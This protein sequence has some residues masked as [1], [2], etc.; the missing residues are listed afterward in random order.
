MFKDLTFAFRWLRKSPGFALAAVATIAL[1][2][3]V[4]TAIFSVVYSLLLKPLPYAAPDQLVMV[5]QDMTERGGPPDEWA[6]PGN[7]VDWRSQDATFASMASIRG[8]APSLTGMGD[9]Q[10]LS[11]ESVTQAYFDVL[12]VQPAIGRA[13]RPDEMVPNAPRVV[14]LSDLM[15]RQRFAGSR[16]ALGKSIMLGGE[17]HEIIGV[18][19]PDFR[20]VIAA[21]AD[22]WRPD[23]LNLANPNRGAIVLRVVGR[24][25]PGVTIAGAS[26]AMTTLA[27]DLSQ[28]FPESNRNVGFRVVSLHQQVVGDARPGVLVL[29]GAVLLVL[30]IA[31]VNIANLLLARGAGRTREMAVRTALGAGRMR[32]VRQL[33]TESVVLAVVGGAAGVL[34]SVWG[35]K[36]LIAIAPA[37]TP[38]LNEVSLDPVVLAMAAGLTVLTGLLFGLAPALQMARVSHSSALKDGGRGTVGGGGH[39]LRRVLIVAEIAVALMLLVGGGLLLRSFVAMERADLGFD[40]SNVLVGALTVPPSRLQDP[41][42][43]IAFYD[44]V[45][46]RAG[47]IAGVRRA[48]LTTIVPLGPGGDN[49]MDFTIEGAPPPAPSQP[50]PVTWYRVVSADYVSVMG[51]TVTRGRTF[52]GREPTPS[53]LISETLANRYWPGADSVGR[54]VRFGDETSPWFT[55]IGVVADIKQ[56]GA[57]G[58]PRG[59]TFIPYWH[60]APLLVGGANVVLKTSVAPDTIAKPFVEAMRGVDSSVPVSNVSPMTSLIAQSVDAP[61]FLALI[62]GVFAVLAMLLAAIGVYGVMAFAVTERRQEIGVRLALGASP[63]DVFGL[64]CWDGMKL[65]AMGLVIGTAGAAALAPSL[66]T[67]LFGIAP[68]DLPTFAVTG[69]GLLVVAL[70]AVAIP[71]RRATRL[72]PATT[73]RG[74]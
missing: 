7:F 53:V 46:E 5:W 69:A 37:A 66:T 56:T 13:F 63:I 39:R 6:T 35:L 61:R 55:V 16:D 64:V 67:L 3:G 42:E 1:G 4:N 73:L 11:G 33:L 59:Q 74:E 62:T 17:P 49:D 44:R 2:I 12:G 31:C 27:T 26:A 30:L 22:V 57:R 29:F 14:I 50:G 60:A 48:A 58:E 38:R 45:L 72:T 24:L 40:P 51:L 9:A 28:R 43:R 36:T 52:E 18:M 23:R 25:K 32:V 10:V 41:A 8:F 54:R 20:P 70:L 71:A 65:A 21:K 68:F 19:P 47:A 34:L 15:W